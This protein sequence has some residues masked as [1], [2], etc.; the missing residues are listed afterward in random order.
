VHLPSHK[1]NNHQNYFYIG[2]SD[3]YYLLI[4]IKNFLN[5]S[6]KVKKKKSRK[7]SFYYLESYKKET[8]KNI[9]NHCISYPLLGE[10]YKSFDNFIKY[11][12]KQ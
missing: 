10:K 5:F 1:R 4:S 7:T 8:L 6:V 9:I 11:I 2:K 3:D 12:N